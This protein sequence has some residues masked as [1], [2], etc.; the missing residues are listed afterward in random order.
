MCAMADNKN[1]EILHQFPGTRQ[2]PGTKPR[3]KDLT[4]VGEKDAGNFIVTTTQILF[5]RKETMTQT[6]GK[7]V[8]EATG[9]GSL[10]AGLPQGLVITDFIGEKLSSARVKMEEVNKILSDDP[11]SLSIPLKNI[12]KVAA[13]RAYMVT[14]YLML[15]YKTPK[16]VE[17]TSFVFGTATRN[18]KELASTIN[19]MMKDA[20]S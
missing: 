17:A 18:Q 7:N 6:L 12:V 4:Y 13:K 11:K 2:Y 3:Y 15:E 20:V 5:L 1:E 19:M 9:I 14:A 8:M 16:G 10:L